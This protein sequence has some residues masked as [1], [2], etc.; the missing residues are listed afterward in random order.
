MNPKNNSH[1]TGQG[2]L[3]KKALDAVIKGKLFAPLTVI[4]T[5]IFFYLLFFRM[6]S[7][8]SEH[9]KDRIT[10][11][12]QNFIVP[13]PSPKK[14]KVKKKKSSQS[15]NEAPANQP[16]PASLKKLYLTQMVEQINQAK[17]YPRYERRR[18]KVGKVKVKLVLN[19]Q[20][21][22]ESLKILRSSRYSGFNQEAADAIQRA[23][24]FGQFPEL[25]SD[26]R[27][28]VIFNIVFRLS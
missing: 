11:P 24:P 15:K 28:S 3:R 23:A 18:N 1:I 6:E 13:P 12:M 20:G 4:I 17:R 16:D 9:D 22:I 2:P 7:P 5:L 10:I 25:L 26:E 27:I 21:R 14:Q 8:T 19:R